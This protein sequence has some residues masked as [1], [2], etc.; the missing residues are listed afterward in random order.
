[1][2]IF[3]YHK[4][5]NQT[6]FILL[7]PSKCFGNCSFKSWLLAKCRKYFYQNQRQRPLFK[8]DPHRI[9]STI[10]LNDRKQNLVKKEK[11]TTFIDNIQLAYSDFKSP[12]NQIFYNIRRNPAG[13][14]DSENGR[15]HNLTNVCRSVFLDKISQNCSDP[16]MTHLQK[17]FEYIIYPG[18]FLLPQNVV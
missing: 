2:T 15:I 6:T 7:T 8:S 12:T 4:E 16:K 9:S 18:D 11:K 17:F 5:T 13:L 1:M 3:F 14:Q 10:F